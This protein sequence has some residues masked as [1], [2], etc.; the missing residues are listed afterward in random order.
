MVHKLPFNTETLLWN[1]SFSVHTFNDS[2]QE[3]NYICIEWTIISTCTCMTSWLNLSLRKLNLT[4]K[5]VNIVDYFHLRPIEILSRADM[6]L[7]FERYCTFF[8][9]ANIAL[10]GASGSVYRTCI[11]VCIYYRCVYNINTDTLP[12]LFPS[13]LWASLWCQV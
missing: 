8:N 7:C 5:S 3:I 11:Q 10:I 6:G 1:V 9:T 12:S 13:S 4:S 2:T